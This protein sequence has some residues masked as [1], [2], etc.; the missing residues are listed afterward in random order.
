MEVQFIDMPKQAKALQKELEKLKNVQGPLMMALQKAQDIYGYLPFEVQNTIAEFFNVPL[1]DLYGITTFY[2]Q[3]DLKPHGKYRVSVCLGTAC[4][5]KGAQPL[6]DKLE[7]VLKV[8][9]GDTTADSR[10][11]L[12]TKR[13]IGCCALAPVLTVND[14]V[15]G[16]IS[17]DEIDGIIKKYL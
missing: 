4:Y 13:C 17:P 5:V 3:F 9:S 2:S 11:T 7:A 12:E 16:K 8:K 15:Y 14:D 6:L 1:Q 10:F